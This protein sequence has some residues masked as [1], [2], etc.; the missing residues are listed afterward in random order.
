MEMPG[1][2]EAFCFP[3]ERNDLSMRIYDMYTDFGLTFSLGILA[4][5]MHTHLLTCNAILSGAFE[6]ARDD[7]ALGRRREARH[8]ATEF[9]NGASERGQSSRDKSHGE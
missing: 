1:F 5:Y 6:S 9:R 8:D 4:L 3:S 2:L 7:I